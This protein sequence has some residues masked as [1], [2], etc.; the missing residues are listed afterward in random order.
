MMYKVV[1]IE[2]ASGA[3]RFKHG[4]NNT[5]NFFQGMTVDLKNGTIDLHR[6]DTRVHISPDERP[7][8]K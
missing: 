4:L 3:V 1:V 8:G 5:G 6:F 2:K 7:D